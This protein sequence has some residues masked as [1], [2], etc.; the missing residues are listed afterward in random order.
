VLA[1]VAWN[2]I[3]KPAIAVLLRSGWGDAAVLSATFLL[4]VFRD[5][6]E[7]IVVGF[8]LGS[9]LFIHRMS[10]AT[11][12]ETARP[13]VAEDRPD[14]ENGRE[15]YDQTAA[16]D[17]DVAIYR[18]SGAL[19]FGAAGSIASVL[20]RISD[21]C[22]ALVIDMSAVPFLDSSGANALEGVARGARRRGVRLVIAGAA[23][24]VRRDLA[25]HGV[26]EPEVA[27]VPDIRAAQA[28]LAT[29]G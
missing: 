14:A 11:A 8:A 28:L 15:S 13:F 3:E 22:R 2:M 4:T 27:H 16:S 20:D 21:R 29:A 26:A 6:T 1:T 19:F 9:V 25:L 23:R 5:L 17:P 10:L 24:D 18:I 7:A 12:V